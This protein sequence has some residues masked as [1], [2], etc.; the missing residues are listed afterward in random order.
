[1][2]N[3]K[4]NWKSRR[5][6]WKWTKVT[7]TS[8]NYSIYAYTVSYLLPLY[9]KS[10][11][12]LVKCSNKL[13]KVF[14]NVIENVNMIWFYHEMPFQRSHFKTLDVW[15]SHRIQKSG[16]DF[17]KTLKPLIQLTVIVFI[18]AEDSQL[19]ITGIS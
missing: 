17:C 15:K 2:L 1:M 12:N 6:L 10:I 16:D 14:E 19:R 8:H 18:H 7:N 4:L 3:P 13:M 9:S 11:R 5:D